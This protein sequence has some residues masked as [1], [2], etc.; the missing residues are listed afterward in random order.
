MA[1]AT[2]I[3]VGTAMFVQPTVA[4]DLIDQL[5]AWLETQGCTSL[6]DIIGSANPRFHAHID[7]TEL[8]AA[9]ASG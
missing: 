5:P 4:M 9:A 6:S 2:A 7:R 3:Q 8:D 1:G